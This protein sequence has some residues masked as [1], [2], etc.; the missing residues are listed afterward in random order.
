MDRFL[1]YFGVEKMLFFLVSVAMSFIVTNVCMVQE[2]SFGVSCIGY[3]VIGLVV[4]VM[5][6]LVK[7]F[8]DSTFG[9]GDFAVVVLGGVLPMAVNAVGVLFYVLSD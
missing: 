7:K 1:V 4:A 9:W 5:A 8:T 2:G 3:G 6:G